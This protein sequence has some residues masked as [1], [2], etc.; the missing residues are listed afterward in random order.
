MLTTFT[1]NLFNC[2]IDQLSLEHY[3]SKLTYLASHPCV[4]FV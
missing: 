1:P 3:S 4:L 2:I